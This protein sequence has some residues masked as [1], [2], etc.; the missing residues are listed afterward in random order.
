MLRYSSIAVSLVA[1]V[2][3]EDFEENLEKQ[4]AVTRA[5]ELIGEAAKS[6]PKEVRELAPDIPW[7]Q[8]TGTRDKLIHQYFGVNLDVIWQVTQ[9]DLPKLIALVAALIEAVNEQAADIP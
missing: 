3:R 7:R 2:S 9:A 5:V 8:I 6:V 4:L 1:D